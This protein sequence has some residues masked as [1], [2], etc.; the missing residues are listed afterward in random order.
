MR[1]IIFTVIAAMALHIGYA[2]SD[3]PAL[4]EPKVIKILVS[5]IYTM[6]GENTIPDEIRGSRAEVR[7][8]VDQGNYLRILS[9]ET[10]N[11]ALKQFIKSS[12]DFQKITKGTYQ[13]GIVYRVPIEVRK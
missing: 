9:I 7:I 10:E 5:Q 6:L 12:I 3:T 1:K 2:F 4:H 8:A 13:Q 11:D